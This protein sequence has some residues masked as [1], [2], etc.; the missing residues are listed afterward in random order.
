MIKETKTQK[1][2]YIHQILIQE[3]KKNKLFLPGLIG[4]NSKEAQRMHPDAKYILWNNE[5]IEEFIKANFDLSVY[6]TYKSITAFAYKADLA[7]YCILYIM[8]GMYI[9]LG[10]R[11]MN[12]WEIP[13]KKGFSTFKEL[14]FT[15]ESWTIMQNGLIWSLPKRRELEICIDWIVNNYKNKFY[16]K[17]PLCP[18]GPVMYGRAIAAAMVEN[19]QSLAADDQWIGEYRWTTPEGGMKNDAYVSPDHKIIAFRTKLVPGDLS[20]LGLSGTNN[21]K[22]IWLSRQMYGEN[23]AIFSFNDERIKF[24]KIKKTDYGL[25]V[26][27]LVDGVVVYGPYIKLR[28]GKYNLAIIF[29][30]DISFGELNVSVTTGGGAKH[31]SHKKIFSSIETDYNQLEFE[32]YENSNLVEFVVSVDKNFFGT[33]VGFEL[34]NLDT[35]LSDANAVDSGDANAVDS[36]DANAVDSGDANAVDSGDANAVDSGDANTIEDLPV[37]VATTS[38]GEVM[39]AANNPDIRMISG[40]RS[41]SGV[42]VPRGTKGR[43]TYGPYYSLEKG[44]YIFS[45]SFSDETKFS[46]IL[47]DIA[48]ANGKKSLSFFKEKKLFRSKKNFL[49]FSLDISDNIPDLEFRVHVY[50]DFQGT[51][52]KFSLKPICA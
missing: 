44:Q 48:Y 14:C 47:V 32:L 15:A 51:I 31:I 18:T 24:N 49:S 28:A 34:K 6:E 40:Q 10:I 1:I 45:V 19:G 27:E 12:P 43:V 16:G 35:S 36:G 9:D 21:Y 4:F 8:G 39:W 25:F 23:T 7:R 29:G 42:F 37:C 50:G 33:I 52:E 26:S 30:E 38:P 17:T 41:N 13:E 20:H 46:K 5:S 2:T 11:M 3:S 22:E